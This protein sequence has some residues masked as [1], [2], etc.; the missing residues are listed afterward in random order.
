ME[1]A[2][3]QNAL[4]GVRTSGRGSLVLLAGEAGI[5][6]TALLD[7]FCQANDGVPTARGECEPL[8]TPRPLG[9]VLEIAQTLG[10]DAPREDDAGITPHAIVQVLV[11]EL[12]RR[13]RTIVVLEDLHWADEATLDV[14]RMLARR[15]DSVPVVLAASYRDDSLATLHPLRTVLGELPSSGSVRLKLTPLS[16]DAVSTLAGGTD[17]E[18]LH[19]QTAG[20]PFFVT[21]VL[22]SGRAEVPPTVREAVLARVARLE[23][24]AR[25]VLHAVAVVP[26]RVE[27][28]LLEAL[29]DD[30]P[31][32]LD[33]CL[34]SGML[35]SAGN[36]VAFR[37]EIARVAVE[38]SLTPHERLALHRRALAALAAE[39]RRDLAR[40]VHHAEAADDDDAV[41]RYAFAA[42]ELAASLAAHREAAAHFARALRFA[43]E[44]PAERRIELLER[45][46][47]ECYLTDQ[48]DDALDAR[49]RAL[50]EHRRRGDRL[51]EG[52]AHRWLSRLA[53]FAGDNA[54]A[55]REALR[56]IE[57]LEP[58][59]P[60][61]E[62]AMAYS[63]LAQL[64][65]L[66][67]DRAAT[68]AWGG[69]A[70]ELAERLGDREILVH[71]LTN[72]GS[73]EFQTGD[74][75]GRRKLERSLELALE[76]GL[77]EHAA[78][79]YTNLAVI[80]I[81]NYDGEIGRSVLEAGIDFCR[82]HDLDSWLDYLLGWLARVNLERG[83]WDAAAETAQAVVR[84]PRVAAPS[85]ITPLAVLGR[86]RARRGEAEVW[87]VL[88]EALELATVTG[89]L[90]RLAP[91]AAARAEVLWLEGQSGRVETETQETLELAL[92]HS[93]RWSAGELCVWRRRAGVDEAVSSEQLAEPFALELAG[94]AEQAAALW[95]SL[96]YPYEAALARASVDSEDLLRRS[97]AELQGLGATR[98]AT[99][100]AR[101]LRERGFRDVRIGPRASTR[102]NPAGLTTRELEVLALLTEGLRNRE[103]AKRLSLSE[104]T[105]DHH[106]SAILRK[107]GVGSRGQAAAEAARMGIDKR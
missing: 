99:R 17:A 66:A 87:P 80:A 96:G 23:P 7:A 15:L 42:G 89:E 74:I 2:V 57:L 72:V 36:A 60:G 102:D 73:A 92:V 70:I 95:E 54:T 67:Q 61:R 46:S 24:A 31:N 105:V 29:L 63:N 40:L 47:Y 88:D 79:A 28:D 44:L 50:E 83:D 106:V 52:D 11:R 101:T 45:R 41:L 107:L 6:K 55:R 26:P 19:R 30:Y 59:P 91:V 9:P 8:F 68:V 100:V 82:E 25:N 4:E 77:Q 20:N 53:W 97:V 94:E 78:R 12:R 39:P 86:L 104:K 84:N 51:R 37:H 71:A 35:V 98:A 33:N 34:A 85:R 103:I 27:L 69:R 90:Q 16:V 10:G 13:H 58:L 76:A 32:G 81:A 62:L 1:L 3:L 21:E 5:G 75:D 22:A 14:V 43:D 56:A 48:M 64:S 38:E 65:M 18:V 49:T 93:D